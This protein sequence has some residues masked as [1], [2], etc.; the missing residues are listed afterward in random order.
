MKRILVVDDEP[1]IRALVAASLETQ[2][3]AV[4]LVADGAA[5]FDAI[6]EQRPDLILLDVGLPR[7]SGCEVLKRLRADETTASIPVVLMT[8]LEPPEDARPDGVLHKPFTPALLI[9]SVASFLS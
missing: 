9:E 7:L 3:C 8:G 5:T 1:A 4:D 6:T 2:D